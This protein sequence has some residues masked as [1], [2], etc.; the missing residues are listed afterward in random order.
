MKARLMLSA[1]ALGV[2]VT[3][4]S[5]GTHENDGIPSVEMTRVAEPLLTPRIRVENDRPDPI[6]VLYATGE[7]ADQTRLGSLG[8]NAIETFAIPEGLNRVQIVVRPLGGGPRFATRP[9]DISPATDVWVHIDANPE[10]SR[11]S[12]QELDLVAPP[13][14]A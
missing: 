2:M 14:D 5:R 9:L 8:P 4:A 10:R 11:F 13:G 3:I 1:A 7:L 6:D 12:V